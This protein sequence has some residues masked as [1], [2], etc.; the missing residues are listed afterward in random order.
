MEAVGQ[1]LDQLPQQGMRAV[2]YAFFNAGAAAYREGHFDRAAKFFDGALTAPDLKM[3]EQ[4][5]YNKGNSLYRLGE[6]ESDTAKKIEQWQLSLT[7]Y[8]NS[9][10]FNPQD[11][12]AKFNYEFVNRKLQELREQQKQQQQQKNSP[13][14]NQD[15]KQDNKDNQ[16]SKPDQQ[17][18]Q[19]QQDQNQQ[20][21][22]QQKQN[23]QANQPDKKDQQPENPGEQPKPD[24]KP[25]EEKPPVNYAAG[26]MT[27]REAEQLLD[28]QKNDEMLLPAR[29]EEG[30]PRRGPIKDW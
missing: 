3:Q 5:Y 13:E 4:A 6:R 2:P 29:P 15:Q 10:R 18:G 22:N 16:Q 25:G 28:S 26:Q 23:Q 14:Q 24:Q 7:N 1:K 9:L 11:A 30:K 19:N 20:N 8:N 27:P 17:Q 21:Q 12:D